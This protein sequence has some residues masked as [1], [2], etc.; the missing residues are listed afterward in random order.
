MSQFESSPIGSVE[1]VRAEHDAGT[2][3]ATVRLLGEHDVSNVA[4]LSAVLQ[5]ACAGRGDVVVEAAGVTF[6]SAATLGAIADRA[7]QLRAQGRVLLIR[8]PSWCTRRLLEVC[9]LTALAERSAFAPARQRD[10][11][12]DGASAEWAMVTV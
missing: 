7:A 8:T 11:G 12:V 1:I 4:E 6:I 10:V 9:E 2:E 3:A 5:L